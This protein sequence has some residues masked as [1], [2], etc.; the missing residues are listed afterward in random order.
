M[1]KKDKKPTGQLEDLKKKLRECQ[2]GKE[3]Y[4]AG[5]QRSRADFINFK[6]EEGE[7]FKK[8]FEVEKTEIILKILPI[9]DNF[10]KATHQ[11]EKVN[12][13]VK[14]FL[15]IKKQL[16]DFLREEGIEEIKC[17]GEKFDPNFHQAVEETEV[18]G[19]ESGEILEVVQKG[20]QLA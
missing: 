8:F 11:Q 4:L 15:Q 12:Q 1:P 19:K 16:E 20:Y 13:I 9:L 6:R 3:E 2:K 17:L 7:R 5:W 18:K 14:G 10:E